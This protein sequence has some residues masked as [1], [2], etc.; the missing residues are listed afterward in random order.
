M[1]GRGAIYEVK[2][3]RMKAGEATHTPTIV[4]VL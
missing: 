4:V 1:A 3:K 2:K